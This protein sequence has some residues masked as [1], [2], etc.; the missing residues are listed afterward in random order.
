MK[1]IVKIKRNH[2]A[3]SLAICLI[4]S[5][6]SV[7]IQANK[8]PYEGYNVN[9]GLGVGISGSIPGIG[10]FDAKAKLNGSNFTGEADL[11]FQ[12]ETPFKGVV[13]DG[14][15]YRIG[16]ATLI[17][18]PASLFSPNQTLFELNGSLDL[19]LHCGNY[20]IDAV[21]AGDMSFKE[22]FEKPF[23]DAWNNIKT[24]FKRLPGQIKKSISKTVNRF[25]SSITRAAVATPG[26]ILKRVN[27]A[28]YEIISGRMFELKM[29]FDDS[30]LSCE[31]MSKT[32]AN[33]ALDGI[34]AAAN[35]EEYKE[36]VK[37]N[38]N[39]Q[40]AR[41]V[42]TE[43]SE[44][45]VNGGI[46]TFGGKK[47]G[48]EN[49]EPIFFTYDIAK[50]GLNAQLGR[51]FGDETK[52]NSSTCKSAEICRAFENSDNFLDWITDV[53][54]DR[55]MQTCQGNQNYKNS[56]DWTFCANKKRKDKAQLKA[57]KGLAYMFEQEALKVSKNLEKALSASVI[58]K[59]MLKSV[60]ADDLQITRGII[61]K[62]K[63]SE[64]VVMLGSRL[65]QEVGIMRTLKKAR[66]ARRAIIA[67]MNDP[68]TKDEEAHSKLGKELLNLL[69]EEIK[70]VKIELEIQKL[71]I[72]NTQQAIISDYHQRNSQYN[73]FEGK[74]PSSVDSFININKEPK[75]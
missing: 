20:D 65:A 45:K 75:P 74:K 9:G 69:D 58:T 54:G 52:V 37:A 8:P 60:S 61:E 24:Q 3:K 32:M 49:Q 15:F 68:H 64:N 33:F 28:L 29:E 67:G 35:R 4:A 39:P 46:T 44:Q 51:N 71:V 16:G 41:E 43:R 21:I 56:S 13:N 1:K 25:L 53:L 47:R 73:N 36:I 14:L 62:L 34:N 57:P 72:G 30:L 48:G 59:E 55:P 38:T 23:K 70:Q 22:F 11:E 7:S 27:P 40:G 10:D 63:G 12:S 19:G 50:A 42:E 26:L 5:V 6:I 66:L 18:R 2:Q 17:H 31:N